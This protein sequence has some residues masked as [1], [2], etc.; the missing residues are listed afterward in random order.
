ML[1]SGEKEV[2]GNFDLEAR[3]KK[4]KYFKKNANSHQMVTDR[5]NVFSNNFRPAKPKNIRSVLEPKTTD[6]LIDIW[7]FDNTAFVKN[8]YNTKQF[9]Y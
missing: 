4:L 6:F 1:K 5:L 9:I 8:I 7:K 3:R 2:L